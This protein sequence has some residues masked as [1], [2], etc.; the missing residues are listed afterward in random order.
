MLADGGGTVCWWWI[1]CRCRRKSP[2]FWGRCH[3]NCFLIVFFAFSALTLLVGRQEGHPACKNWVV[4]YWHGYL[5]GAMC[6]Q[7]A[8]GPADH[9]A[10]PSSLAPIKSRFQT[11]LVTFYPC[12]PGKEAVKRIWCSSSS[13]YCIYWYLFVITCNCFPACLPFLLQLAR[14][15]YF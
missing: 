7:F 2:W 1:C 5:S 11:F 8:Y 4:G 10:T 9:T 13:L 3:F 12:C 14:S 6:K 15:V